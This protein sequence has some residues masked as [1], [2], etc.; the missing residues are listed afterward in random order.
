MTEYESRGFLWLVGIPVADGDNADFYA[1]ALQDVEQLLAPT[2]C[3]YE[4]FTI[5]QR[6]RGEDAAL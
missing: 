1:Q 6:Q 3:M 5:V 2:I 4:V